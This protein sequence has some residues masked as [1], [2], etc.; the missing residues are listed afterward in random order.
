M[1]GYAGPSYVSVQQDVI[2]DYKTSER[3]PYDT[4]G[5]ASVAVTP[6]KGSR[7]GFHVGTDVSYFFSRSFGV[8]GSLQYVQARVPLPATAGVTV[9]TTAGGIQSGL[10]VRVRF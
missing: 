10:G 9:N 7:A 3:Y 8:S 5:L 1:G 4:L 6:K 2:T